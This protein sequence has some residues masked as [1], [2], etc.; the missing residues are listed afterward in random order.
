MQSLSLVFDVGSTLIHPNFETLT[1]WVRE[2][3]GHSA[4][5][6]AVERAFR[7]AV[8]G[9]LFSKLHEGVVFFERCGVSE[10]DTDTRRK[11]WSEIETAGGDN[12]WLYT[13]VDEEAKPTLQRLKELNVNLIAASNS[14]GSLDSELRSYDLLSYFDQTYDSTQ[15]GVE[16]PS[17]QFY[18]HVISDKHADRYIHIGDDFINDFVGPMASGFDQA[19]LIDPAS[20]YSRLP[21]NMFLS[22]LSDLCDLV[23]RRIR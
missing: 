20:I 14:D 9:D 18:E 3:T 4:S 6:I 22:S 15:L 13:V 7:I 21:R 17:Y 2:K 11:Y 1:K 23:E 16:K 8:S 5:V 12:S 10:L 19:Y